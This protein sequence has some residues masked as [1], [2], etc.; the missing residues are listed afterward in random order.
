[1]EVPEQQRHEPFWPIA[2]LDHLKR[3]VLVQQGRALADRD[4]ALVYLPTV[5]AK[6]GSQQLSPGRLFLDAISCYTVFAALLP[7]FPDQMMQA[8]SI[9]LG[10]HLPIHKRE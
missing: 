4:T 3:P 1:M 8:L 5:Q 2:C 6:M 9:H 7:T 10:Y